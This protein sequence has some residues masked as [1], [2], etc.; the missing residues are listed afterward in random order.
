MLRYQ[1]KEH[2]SLDQVPSEGPLGE[3][4]TWYLLLCLG[5]NLLTPSNTL[6]RV[7]YY[8]ST[9]M[10]DL[11]WDLSMQSREC[12]PQKNLLCEFQHS[13][14]SVESTATQKVPSTPS[15][16]VPGWEK[17]GSARDQGLCYRSQSSNGSARSYALALSSNPWEDYSNSHTHTLSIRWSIAQSLSRMARCPSRQ[18]WTWEYDRLQAYSPHAG[19]ASAHARFTVYH[20]RYGLFCRVKQLSAHRH[21]RALHPSHHLGKTAASTIAAS[22]TYP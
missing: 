14:P 15:E 9:T 1:V 7:R 20:S 3:Y 18:R 22:G 12:S 16:K 11:S 4:S 6:R 21:L 19:F 17:T 2:Y 10:S 13:Q 8:S 5:P